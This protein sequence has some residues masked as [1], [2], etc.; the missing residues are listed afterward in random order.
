MRALELY[1]ESLNPR[2]TFTTLL[3]DN[4]QDALEVH[5]HIYLF[6]KIARKL[7]CPSTLKFKKK[8]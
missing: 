8:V 4:L 6:L 5:M 3:C 1:I 2:C 7:L